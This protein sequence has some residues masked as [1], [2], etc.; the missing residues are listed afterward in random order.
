LLATKALVCTFEIDPTCI[1]LVPKRHS[2]VLVQ[3]CSGFVRGQRFAKCMPSPRTKQWQ[4][5]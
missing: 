4:L 2:N 5:T 1:I 3:E